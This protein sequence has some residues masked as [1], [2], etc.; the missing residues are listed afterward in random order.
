MVKVS[1]RES[2]QS[3]EGILIPGLGGEEQLMLSHRVEEYPNEE[4]SFSIVVN[5]VEWLRSSYAGPFA[6]ERL[7]NLNCVDGVLFVLGYNN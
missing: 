7:T 5:S 6:M 4:N 2:I 1:S 3:G